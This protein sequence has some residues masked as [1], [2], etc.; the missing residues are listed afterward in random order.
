SP[1]TATRLAPAGSARGAPLPLRRRAGRTS[2]C[3]RA[4]GRA[5]RP[6]PRAR[7]APSPAPRPHGTGDSACRNR[8]GCSAPGPAEH[9]TFAPAG[10]FVEQRSH[11][12]EL[13]LLLVIEE[14]LVLGRAVQRRGRGG[15]AGDDLGDLVEVARAYLAL[16]LDGG[17]ALFRRGELLLLQ[18][19]E[20]AHAAARIA[21]GELEHRVVE[22]VEA[23]EGDELELVAHGAELA[24]ELGDG[25]VVEVAFPVERR[26][27]VVG[28][29]LAGVRLLHRLGELACEVE[30]GL[31]GLAPHHVGVR[32]I[33]HAAGD[34]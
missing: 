6:R 25:G 3:A 5:S 30:I 10:P 19:N 11:R 1:A 15:A 33:G 17:E 14:L 27:A 9:W 2:G 34:G 13:G 24:L 22:R 32:R 4:P 16:V 29:H 8:R 28:E 23:G 20:R 21:V 31:A 12:G 18:L 7:R 26:R